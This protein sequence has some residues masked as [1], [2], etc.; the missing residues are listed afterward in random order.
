MP[1]PSASRQQMQLM[2][3]QALYTLPRK[4][5]YVDCITTVQLMLLMQRVL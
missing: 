1:F 2:F 4:R 3:L 5:S